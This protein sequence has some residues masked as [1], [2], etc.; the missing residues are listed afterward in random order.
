MIIAK[1]KKPPRKSEHY[2]C[3][4]HLIVARDEVRDNRCISTYTI[5]I[6]LY[7]GLHNESSAFVVFSNVCKQNKICELEANTQPTTHIHK[8]KSDDVLK[9]IDH[10]Q[11]QEKVLVIFSNCS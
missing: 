10:R 2:V 11:F 7:C 5:P 1:R 8:A 9:M 6:H 3:V 4:S